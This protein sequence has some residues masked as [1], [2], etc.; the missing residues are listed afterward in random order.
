MIECKWYLIQRC[1]KRS[2]SAGAKGVDKIL[3]L[4]YMGSAELKLETASA[5]E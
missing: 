5:A 2:S 4:D 3:S 1:E